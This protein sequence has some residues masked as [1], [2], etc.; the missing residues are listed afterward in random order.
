MTICH[1]DNTDLLHKPTPRHPHPPQRQHRHA[2][3]YEATAGS[4]ALIGAKPDKESTVALKL[5]EAGA[6]VLGKAAMTEWANYRW[7]NAATGWS[8][9]GGQCTG[10]FYPRMKASGSS[11]GSAVSPALGLSFAGIGT[12]VGTVTTRECFDTNMVVD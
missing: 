10:A 5:R 3:L 4:L 6:I 11:T 9:R 8:P 1:Y 12:E 7:T 2:G